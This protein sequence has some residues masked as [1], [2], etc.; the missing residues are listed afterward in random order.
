MGTSSSHGSPSGGGLL[1]NWYND[2]QVLDQPP[3][4]RQEPEPAGEEVPVPAENPI[5]IIPV[6]QTGADIGPIPTVDWSGAKAAFTRYINGTAGSSLSKASGN[7]VR[8]M[9]GAGRA[10]RAARRGVTAGGRLARILGTISS[11]GGGFNVTLQAFGIGNLVGRS[12]EEVLAQLANAIAP[13]GATNDEAIA[14]DAILATLDRLCE[15][16]MEEDGNFEP[17]ENLTPEDIRA[18]MIEY[19]NLYIFNKWVYE[20]GVA[21][22]TNAVSEHE[23]VQLEAEVRDFVFEEVTTALQDVP[24]QSFSLDEGQNQQIIQTI[25]LNAYA[26]LSNEDI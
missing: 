25:F 2:D 1:P 5:L 14:R 4:V 12:T 11:P 19:V 17:L 13:D 6:S 20:L 21:I 9:G 23:A 26:T 3:Q 22:E 16:R 10:A 15:R 7:Y 18:I 8:A 24:L